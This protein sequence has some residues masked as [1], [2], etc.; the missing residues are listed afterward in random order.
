MKKRPNEKMFDPSDG[1]VSHLKSKRRFA[2]KPTLPVNRL[3]RLIF[4]KRSNFSYSHLISSK[5]YAII[6]LQNSKKS[7]IA[8]KNIQRF[9]NR[10]RSW[11]FQKCDLPIRQVG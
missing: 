7:N 2:V 8:V 3:F 9:N 5:K 4:P 10:K 6:Y 1:F 11:N